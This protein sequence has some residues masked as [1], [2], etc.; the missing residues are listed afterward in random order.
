MPALYE[1]VLPLVG[2]GL[3]CSSKVTLTPEALE[4][5]EEDGNPNVALEVPLSTTWSN[6]ARVI[7]SIIIK[8]TKATTNPNP[9]AVE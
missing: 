9:L 6:G 4:I 1:N 3:P 7:P 2:I 5:S 8:M